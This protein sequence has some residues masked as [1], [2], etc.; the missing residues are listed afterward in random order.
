MPAGCGGGSPETLV[1]SLR[2]SSLPVPLRLLRPSFP[3]GCGDAAISYL[4]H[5][6]GRLGLAG[7]GLPDCAL[8]FVRQ[9]AGG[10]GGEWA[11]HAGQ[12]AATLGVLVSCPGYDVS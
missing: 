2:L 8:A 11:G 3:R 12:P 1:L 4:C 7:E 9:Q 10:N 6:T 5:H